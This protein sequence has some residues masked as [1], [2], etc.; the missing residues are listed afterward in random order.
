MVMVTVRTP[1]PTIPYLQSRV[2]KLCIEGPSEVPRQMDYKL[3][4]VFPMGE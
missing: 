4:G 2:N 3:K 1:A